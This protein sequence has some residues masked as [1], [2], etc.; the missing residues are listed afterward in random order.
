M[1]A[2]SDPAIYFESPLAFRRWLAAHHETATELLVGFHKR[3]T[4]RPTMTWPESVDEALCFGWIDGIRRSV[5]DERYTIRFTPRRPH[6]V[7]S[8]INVKRVAALTEEGRMRPAGL[9][10][11][12]ARRADRTGVASFER[13][14][15]HLEPEELQ[16]FRK[17][18]AAW[19]FWESQPPGYRKTATH[20]VVSAK[21]TE[22][23][24]RR[25]AVL[26]DDSAAGVRIA[27]LRRPE[28][29]A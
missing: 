22:T 27:P 28:K 5:D 7:W 15:Q 4:A 17:R 26:I 24:A 8:L 2:A 10:V 12:A 25:L 13:P 6:S 23:R 21:K 14:L 11:F 20:W 19:R 9:R 16:Q 18:A 29:K 1:A 3:H